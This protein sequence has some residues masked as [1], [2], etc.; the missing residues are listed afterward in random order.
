MGGVIEVV[1]ERLHVNGA[2]V[3]ANDATSP[4]GHIEVK[5]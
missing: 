2:V 4:D 3:T 5:W 1:F